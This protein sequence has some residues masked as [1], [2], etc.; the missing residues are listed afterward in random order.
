MFVVSALLAWFDEA[1]E[2][3]DDPFLRDEEP[4]E[5]WGPAAAATPAPLA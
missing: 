2:W 4:V 1:L 3:S 5:S